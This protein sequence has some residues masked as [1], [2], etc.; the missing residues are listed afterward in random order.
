MYFSVLYNYPY[1]LV[2]W[3]TKNE[4]KVKPEGRKKSPR[5]GEVTP[6][7]HKPTQEPALTVHLFQDHVDTA[8]PGP[9]RGLIAKFSAAQEVFSRLLI[10]EGVGPT[11]SSLEENC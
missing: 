8:L 2:I 6:T 4:D 5:V 1:L 7:G 11:R 10:E 9:P 3:E